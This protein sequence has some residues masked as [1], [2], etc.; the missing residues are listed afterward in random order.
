MNEQGD[1]ALME[2]CAVETK[3]ALA[4]T[5]HRIGELVITIPT[6]KFATMIELFLQ[7]V[8]VGRKFTDLL[9]ALEKSDLK[10]KE[11]TL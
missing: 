1:R 11:G 8:E 4:I 7:D 10:A 9:A 3:R 6:D 5:I 2:V